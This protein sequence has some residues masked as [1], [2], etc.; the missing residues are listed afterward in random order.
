MKSRGATATMHGAIS[1][2]NAIAT[3]NGSSLGIS[4]TATARVELEKGH[5]V[6]FLTGRN[7]DRLVNNIVRNTLPRTMA[8]ENMVTVSV[9]SEIPIGFGLKSSSAVS[10]AVA[11]ACSRLAAEEVDDIAVLDAAVRAS[12]DARVSITGAY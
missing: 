5:G 11:L 12:L 4:L 10:N 2:V 7:E 3:G 8:E 1:V 6:R 9:K